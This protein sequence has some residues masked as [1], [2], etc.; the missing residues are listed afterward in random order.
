MKKKN[1]K[2]SVREKDGEQ[3]RHGSEMLRSIVEGVASVVG[4][5]F[6]RSLVRSLSDTLEVK[7]A[8]IAELLEESKRLRLLA[9]WGGAGFVEDFDCNMSTSPCGKVVGGKTYHCPRGIQSQFPNDK[10]LSKLNIESGLV[11]PL[12]DDDDVMLGVLAVFDDKPMEIPA[13]DLEIVK[14]FAGRAKAELERKL[15][16]EAH[17]RS[18]RRLAG[19]L[20]TAMDAIITI[21]SNYKIFIFNQSAEN[22]F[23]CSTKHVLNN[24]FERFLTR[25]FRHLFE[26]YVV[27]CQKKKALV[28]YIWAS[29]GITATRANGEEFPFEGT[30]SLAVEGVGKYYTIILRDISE[31]VRAQ[32]EIQRLLLEREYL[33]EE[34]NT[35]HNFDGLIGQS[36]AFIKILENVEKVAVTD[37]PV[38]ITGETGTGKELI[39]HKIHK[40]SKRSE[41]A[42]IKVNTAALPLSLVESEFFGHEKGAF[43][44]AI[45]RKLGRFELADGGTIFL[46]EIGDVPLDVQV[47]LL[48]VLQENEFERVGGTETK[49]V[50]ARLIA[51]TNCDLAKAV[52]GGK[53]RDDLYY[54]LNVFPIHV[55]PLRERTDDI[56]LLVHYF[57]GKHKNRL[58]VRHKKID[59]KTMERLVQY[60][61]P[62]N[63]RELSNVIERAMIISSGSELRIELEKILIRGSSVTME[64]VE[65]S[66]IHK[67][68]HE[69]NWV[70]NGPRGAA[71]ILGL[72]PNTLRNRMKKLGIVREAREPEGDHS[73][74]DHNRGV[75]KSP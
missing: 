34:M 32:R 24:S 74:K 75:V 44:G 20:A 67:V 61:W 47:K 71:Q 8:Y 14:I 55:P 7:C 1:G 57:I 70:I 41:R 30:I 19:I 73:D 3:S 35:L 66:H 26:Q 58:G 29:E 65:R 68:L 9:F 25:K 46:D 22:I 31:R 5:E 38:L 10:S 42:L 28:C 60:H 36:P 59:D 37:T 48:R 6:F 63:I 39:A 33:E 50:N 21:D 56:P 27:S 51:A 13:D 40:L 23:H 43:T 54:R 15:A 16:E 62:G 18:E 49:K 2:K 52:V 11:I 69:T 72:H 4:E 45:N 64:D 12:V 17:A 53:F